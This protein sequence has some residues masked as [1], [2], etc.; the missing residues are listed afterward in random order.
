[1]Q[2]R[3]SQNGLTL[4]ELLIAIALMAV[5]SLLG[6]RGLDTL[7]RSQDITQQHTQDVSGVQTSL[8]QWR[9]DLNAMQ[10]VSGLNDAGVAWDGR[11]LRL[12]RRNSAHTPSGQEDGLWVVAWT[13]QRN[14]S[15]GQGQWVRWQSQ[16]ATQLS[17][18]R[19]AWDFAA[20]WGQGVQVSPAQ[21]T[22]L[23]PLD[24]WQIFY[25]RSNAWSNP[26]SST[27]NVGNTSTLPDA[28]R[29]TIDLPAGKSLQGRLTLDWSRPNFSNTK[30]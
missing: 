1:M 8:A 3:P 15:D 10:V 2:T 17:S 22:V 16:A 11:V 5:L 19:Q 18:L 20:Q 14:A 28:I 30:S 25:L 7:M 13:L 23:I 24:Q 12:I 9:S 6:W 29:L 21:E 4:V 27:G 26:L